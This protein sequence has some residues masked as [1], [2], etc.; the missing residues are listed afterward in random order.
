MLAISPYAGGGAEHERP[1]CLGEHHADGDIAEAREPSG[2]DSLKDAPEQERLDG[3][4]GGA[5]RAAGGIGQGGDD[6]R[7][8][9]AQP[10]GEL[11]GAGPARIEPVR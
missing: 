6:H 7:R 11:A 1:Q 3:R 4:R 5:E 2:P 9:K 10:M 8:A